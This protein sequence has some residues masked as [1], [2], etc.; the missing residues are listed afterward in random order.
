VSSQRFAQLLTE[1]IHRIRLSTS[2]SIQA[3]QDEL[4]YALGRKG[5]SAI[6]Y[7]RKGHLPP[8]LADIEA[9]ARVMVSQARMDRDWLEEFLRCAKHPAPLE[10]CEALF[11]SGRTG[12]EKPA[13]THPPHAAPGGPADAHDAAHLPD[14]ALPDPWP[15]QERHAFVVG[16]P[17][18]DPRHFFGRT[19]ELKYL[20]GLWSHLPL[21]HVAVVGLRRSG[22]TSLLRYLKCFSTSAA[23]RIRPEHAAAWAALAGRYRWVFVDFQDARMRTRERLL[24]H[25]LVSLSLPVPEPCD[26]YHFMDVIGEQLRTPAIVLMDELSA[27]LTSPELDLQF[28]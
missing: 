4:G 20:F 22:K 23:A 14:G 13:Q 27:G 12:P 26:L 7:W 17:I 15:S 19:H 3:V 16:P 6:E 25:V 28:W 21:Q 9:L 8:R 18:A 24:R 5:G 1:G 11:A 2:K 10:L